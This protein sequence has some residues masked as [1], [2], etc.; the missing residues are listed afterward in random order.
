[1]VTTLHRSVKGRTR[2]KVPG[3]YRSQ[4]IKALLEKELGQHKAIINASASSLTGN[5][6]V[7]YNSG[8]TV[9]TISSLV[10]AILKNNGHPVRED[11]RKSAAL[12]T[13][14]QTVGVEPS[15]PNNGKGRQAAAK[16]QTAQPL[17]SP[18][19]P[20]RP[21]RTAWH[22]LDAKDIVELMSSHPKQGLSEMA[23][24][25]R[26]RQYGLNRLPQKQP[27]NQWQIFMEQI[28]SLPVYLLGAAAGV[29]VLTG[30]VFDA[31]VIMGVVAANAVIGCKTEGEA[32]KTIQSLQDL[33][34]PKACVMRGAK[35]RVIEVEE[36]VP[37]DLLILK[38]GTYVA[39]D[40]RVISAEH[41][42]IDE[43]MLTGESMPVFK[44]ADPLTKGE[45]P[46]ADRQNTVYMGTL[47]TGGQ[48]LAIVV[49]TAQY[50]QIGIL[51]S[52]LDD[53]MTPRT[54]IERQLGTLGDQLVM[55]C[56]GICGVVFGIGF[57][58]GYGFLQM[59]NMAISL[60]ASAV[61]EGLP[62]AATVNFA[63]GITRMQK[64]HVLIR[65]LQAVETIGSVQTICLDKT[66]T[67]TENK[68]TVLKLFADDQEVDLSSKC[69]V[70]NEQCIKPLQY[71]TIRLIVMV[72]ALC[73]E[74]K[75]DG[76][77]PDGSHV[78]LGSATE[79]ALINMAIEAGV[80]IQQ[81]RHS[82]PL[83]QIQHRSENRQFMGTLHETPDSGRFFALKGSPPDVLAMCRW[84]SI[85]GQTIPLTEEKRQLI[86]RENER[87]AGKALRVLGFAYAL[88]EKMPAADD[89]AE[90][91]WLGLVGMAD[92]IREGVK[93]LIQAFHRAGIE[94]VMITGDQSNT[95]YAIGEELNISGNKPL[96]I[97]DST[98]LTAVNPETLKALASK[99]HVYSRVSPAHKLR[100][101]QALQE[102][103]QTVA[104]TGDG[105]N[106]GPALKA[107]D[108][109]IAMGRSGTDVAREVADIVL[110]KDNLETLIMAV[111]D[112]RST[113]GN[114][115]KSVKFFLSTNLSEI[116]V[117]FAAMALG[118]G[119]PLSVIQLLWINIISDIFPG[120]AL[121]MEEPEEDVMMQAPR[122]TDAPLFSTQDYKRMAVE[123]AVISSASLASYGYGIAR[124]GMG[125]QATGL[126]FQSLTISQLLHALS[127]RSEKHRI[128]SK[129]AP[130]PNPYLRAAIGGSLALQLLTMV[131]PPLRNLLGLAP[132][133]LLD[134]AVIGGSS[135]LTLTL[136][137]ATKKSE[138]HPH[139]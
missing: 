99:V 21:M 5:L 39:A 29:S 133:G 125:P 114:I 55:M 63:L 131:F 1:M 25:K 115:R 85:N 108:L 17:T 22:M 41:L 16:Q 102:A 93:E 139:E 77:R 74:S 27:R 136:N 23:A 118:I 3:L 124:Y 120:L 43:S 116:M 94:T 54:P 126:A 134:A 26:I 127:C 109:G 64:H 110:E 119:F 6:L 61:P 2:Y 11:A 12:T 117:M 60:A 34:H 9:E 30:G 132:M 87:M 95:A 13:A 135:L 67:I 79:N 82:H 91:I 78:I 137:D 103:G 52:L 44:N 138:G 36:V 100:I 14:K 7:S 18:P 65:Q 106:D 130:P 112:G 75:I 15:P 129:E 56:G 47:V 20:K 46:L 107:A 28:N 92:P 48:G 57:V 68:M 49:A 40:A 98:E 35:R 33:V 88:T 59:L 123:S 51:K 70:A 86:E 42:S 122:A 50:T 89:Q 71:E 96:E 121:S 101:V 53:T 105:I 37:G 111:E 83:L 90:L 66:G 128:L 58:R 24:R 31:V 32:D 73:N 38:P 10:E 45:I 81:T 69:F 80:D 104:M 8:N 84:I 76:Q 62:A 97:L 19:A 4:K 113:H 72:S